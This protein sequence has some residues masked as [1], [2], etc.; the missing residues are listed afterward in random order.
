[1]NCDVDPIL[2]LRAQVEMGCVNSGDGVSRFLQNIISNT[3][4]LH[5]MPSPKTGSIIAN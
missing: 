4:S 3:A 5:T 1:M 2:E